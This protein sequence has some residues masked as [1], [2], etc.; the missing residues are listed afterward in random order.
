[1]RPR[2]VVSD[3][4]AEERRKRTSLSLS[5][6][7]SLS[8][9][10]CPL[11]SSGDVTCVSAASRYA[12]MIIRLRMSLGAKEP[13]SHVRLRLTS[14]LLV[15]PRADGERGSHP[16]AFSPAAEMRA[17]QLLSFSE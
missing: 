4:R 11:V 9:S 15:D 3:N 10:L 8:L 17:T 12:R 13:Q 6:S 16:P 7:L 2:I 5:F 14:A 1:M